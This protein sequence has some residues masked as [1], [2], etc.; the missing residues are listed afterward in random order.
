MKMTQEEIEQKKKKLYSIVFKTDTRAGFRFDL[1]LLYIILFSVLVAIL[2]S[3]PIFH[4]RFQ[5]IFSVLEWLITAFFAFEYALRIYISPVKRKYIFSLY[6]VIDLLAI[7]P[8]FI[9]LFIQ[10]SN[11]LVVIR[12]IRLL[13]IFRILQLT[14]FIRESSHLITAIR[15]SL[16]KIVIFIFFVMILVVILGSIM[17]VV[18]APYNES[19]SDIPKSIYWAIVTITTVGYGD[20]TPVTFLGQLISA[21][22]MLLGYAFIAVPTGIFSSEMIRQSKKLK[23]VC[24]KCRNSD[25]DKDAK[26][27]KLCGTKLVEN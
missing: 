1:A 4:E 2:D 13:R 19:F 18:E 11:Y 7:L 14:H 3:V 27:C 24:P 21:I 5:L 25:H 9:G 23:T 26:F 16:N 17:Y 12:A 10:G 6:G 22:I 20:I 8:S 15:K